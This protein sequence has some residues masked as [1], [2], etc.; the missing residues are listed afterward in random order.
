MR[1]QKARSADDN[2][3]SSRP[4]REECVPRTFGTKWYTTPLEASRGQMNNSLMTVTAAAIRSYTIE[5]C[6]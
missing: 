2:N 1:K 3:G 5:W 6:I 4:E